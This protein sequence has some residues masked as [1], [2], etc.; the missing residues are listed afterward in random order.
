MRPCKTE[1]MGEKWLLRQSQLGLFSN[2]MEVATKEVVSLV[3]KRGGFWI[4][5]CGHPSTKHRDDFKN[6]NLF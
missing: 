1:S 2:K 5:T 4:S 6:G 3:P